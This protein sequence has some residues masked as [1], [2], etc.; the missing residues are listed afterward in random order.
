VDRKK[1]I[2]E[3]DAAKNLGVDADETQRNRRII[4]GTSR[5]QTMSRGG[6]RPVVS[7]GKRKKEQ[8]NQR[9]RLGGGNRMNGKENQRKRE[10]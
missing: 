9:W 5:G 7:R 4:K 10:K 2:M 1:K 6:G 3:D 8:E